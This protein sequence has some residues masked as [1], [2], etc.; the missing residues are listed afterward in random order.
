MSIAPVH[1]PPLCTE[2]HFAGREMRCFA[3]RLPTIDAVLR[4]AAATS[5]QEA[6]VCGAVRLNW[7]QVNA[8]SSRVAA[9]LA[10]RGVRRGDRVGLLMGN[11]IEFVLAFFAIAKLG[12]IS[13]PMSTRLQTAEIQYMLAD[14]SAH[15]L[16]FDADICDRVPLDDPQ[17]LR[18]ATGSAWLDLE[19]DGGSVPVLDLDEESVGVILYT[20]GTTGRP[21]GAMLTQ[22]NLVH[23]VMH[24]QFCMGMNST[25]RS[26][27]AVPLSHVTGLVAQLLTMTF[28]GGT[29]VL[30]SAFKAAD[31]ISL[32]ERERM[33]H[34][35]MVPAMYKLCLMQNEFAAHD[36]S[37]WRIGAYGGAPMPP[38]NIEALHQQLPTLALINAYGATETTSPATTMPPMDTSSRGDSVGRAVLCGDIE[39]R[40]A[41]GRTVNAGETGEIWISGPMVVPGYWN[42]PAATAD[43]FVHGWWRSGDIGSLDA[44]GFL[45]VLDRL[46]DVVNRGGYKVYSAEVEALLASH[47]GVLEAAVV[48]LPCPVLGERVHAFVSRRQAGLDEAALRSFCAARIADYKVPETWTLSSDPLPRNANGKLI[49]RM[50]RERLTTSLKLAN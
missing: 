14:C 19:S 41:Q 40:D 26:I 4:R 22:L 39:V 1:I 23:S 17:L 47:E 30:M 11:C 9:G 5:E 20:S 50:L 33:T 44:D 35:V 43:A 7:A 12:A 6:L 48:G 45:R 29:L 25:D 32:A 49:K 46:K 2:F 10:A 42:D 15:A 16:I 28:C 27:V 31:F 21:K 13:V 38:A 18:I 37:A 3:K 8:R 24:Y 34:T 36:L